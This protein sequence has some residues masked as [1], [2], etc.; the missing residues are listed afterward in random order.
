MTSKIHIC[1]DCHRK[2]GSDEAVN[3]HR[4]A[5]H[6]VKHP[7]GCEHCPSHFENQRDLNIHVA[8]AHPEPP[9]CIECG[10]VAVL[11]KGDAIYPHRPD[12]HHKHFYRCRCGAY[13]GC[14]PGTA[15]PLGYPCGPETRRAR[16]AAHACFDPIWRNKEM[17]RPSAYAWLAKETGIDP[18]ACHIGMMNKEQA[19][20]VVHVC[21]V[22]KV[23]V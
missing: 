21:K 1:P 4:Q 23:D 12:L 5:K 8:Q 16:S 9:A 19:E 10:N 13:C 6:G 7:F 17:S 3:S 18:D 11:V 14:H 22:R 2:F 15:Q 20:L